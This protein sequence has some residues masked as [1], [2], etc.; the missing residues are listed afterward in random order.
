VDRQGDSYRQPDGLTVA[1]PLSRHHPSA[2]RN[3]SPSKD[4]VTLDHGVFMSPGL[5]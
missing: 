3:L 2:S 5:A 1:P 4:S